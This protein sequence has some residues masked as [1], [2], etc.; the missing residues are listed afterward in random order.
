MTQENANTLQTET[1]ESNIA[2]TESETTNESGA[3]LAPAAGENQS[4]NE[5]GEQLT[6]Q[7]KVQKAINKQHFK[8][9]EEER[10]RLAAEEREKELQRKLAEY[11]S[12]NSEI[13]IPPMPNPFDE[14]FESKV[15]DRDEAIRRVA[16]QEAEKKSM[17]DEQ[18]RNQEAA[19]QKENERIQAK[20]EKYDQRI[21]TL[22]LTKDEIAV[23][24]RT[25]AEY[26]IS[27]DVA[28]FILDHEQGPLITK[29]LANNPVELD[30]IRSMNPIDAAFKI[31]STIA[32]AAASLKP[33]ATN[34]PDPAETLGGRGAVEQG[35]SLIKGA[36]FE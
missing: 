28:E 11:E 23:A 5:D 19:Q 12:K 6:E 35:S 25:V 15:K 33:Q 2:A 31:N 29:Y 4:K 1:E 14:D 20:A 13:V 10:K 7:E 21:E 18:Q 24:G 34:T 3:G 9:R 30:E 22:G 26:G 16:A 32:V 27:P 17:Q 8:Y 36:T